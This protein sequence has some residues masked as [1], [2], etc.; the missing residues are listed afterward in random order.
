M[1]GARFEIHRDATGE[2]HDATGDNTDRILRQLLEQVREL[3][4]K[5]DALLALAEDH[6]ST[7][8]ERY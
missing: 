8:T 1:I 7:E 3:N 5:I 4:A 2:Q 6:L